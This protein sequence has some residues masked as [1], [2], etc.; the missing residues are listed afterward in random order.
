MVITNRRILEVNEQSVP[1]CYKD[2][3]DGKQKILKLT[4][5]QFTQ[6]FLLHVVPKVLPRF[7][8]MVF[9]LILKKRARKARY[10]NFLRSEGPTKRHSRKS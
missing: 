1:F 2:Y 9:S 7:G 8:M 4:P 3:H 5:Q 10:Y 6:R